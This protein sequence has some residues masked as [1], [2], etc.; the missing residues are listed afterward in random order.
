MDLLISS[1][2]TISTFST[3]TCRAALSGVGVIIIII[4]LVINLITN[5]MN[6]SEISQNI[7]DIHGEI[8]ALYILVLGACET[9][10]VLSLLVSYYRLTTHLTLSL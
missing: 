8:F 9:A 3:Q 7:D 4:Q 1:L 6:F 5:F 10:L 2:L